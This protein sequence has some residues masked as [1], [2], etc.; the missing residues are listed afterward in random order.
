[1]QQSHAA[2]VSH[3]SSTFL[4]SSSLSRNFS[5]LSSSCRFHSQS[6]SPPFVVPLSPLHSVAAPQPR[7]QL[8]QQQQQTCIQ[9]PSSPSS[10]HNSC[11]P[12][13]TSQWSMT[14]WLMSISSHQVRQMMTHF[15]VIHRIMI[16]AVFVLPAELQGLGTRNR[17]AALVSIGCDIAESVCDNIVFPHH[18]FIALMFHL[19]FSALLLT[20]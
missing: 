14:P 8:V 16:I 3:T 13:C 9:F 18:E 7:A 4:S 20:P 15:N 19:V 11:H 12:P 17:H 6:P 5:S 2:F 10:T 1:M